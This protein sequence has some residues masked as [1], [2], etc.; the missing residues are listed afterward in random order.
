MGIGT[1]LHGVAKFT[2]MV[3][4]LYCF[5]LMTYGRTTSHKFI[6]A[7]LDFVAKSRLPRGIGNDE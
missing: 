4:F 2:P 6:N 5:E 1:P 7:F 3:F